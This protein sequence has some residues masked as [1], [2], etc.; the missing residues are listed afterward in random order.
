[1]GH[2][3]NNLLVFSHTKAVFVI[4]IKKLKIVT[5]LLSHLYQMLHTLTLTFFKFI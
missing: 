5:F 1:M 4:Y 2:I 3:R